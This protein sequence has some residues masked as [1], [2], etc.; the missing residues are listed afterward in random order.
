M[1]LTWLQLTPL[2]SSV[3]QNCSNSKKLQ[4]WKPRVFLENPGFWSRPY[5]F[6]GFGSHG[7]TYDWKWVRPLL[8]H[9]FFPIPK[10]VHFFSS[11]RMGSWTTQRTWWAT[12]RQP[13]SHRKPTQRT[14]CRTCD[15]GFEVVGRSTKKNQEKSGKIDGKAHKTKT[16]F[17][18]AVLRGLV[19]LRNSRTE[20]LAYLYGFQ[21]SGKQKNKHPFWVNNF[22]AKPWF[23]PPVLERRFTLS[24]TTLALQRCL[25]DVAAKHDQLDKALKGYSEVADK[26]TVRLVMVDGCY[27]DG[28][29]ILDMNSLW[30]WCE[31]FNQLE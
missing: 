29:V 5:I 8:P 25:K 13:T 28:G 6:F 10:R 30:Y 12:R 31:Y 19:Q 2:C 17:F 21:Q 15:H 26:A 20:H 11:L 1:G 16:V 22:G 18:K 7:Y 24:W 9:D 14:W 3:L 23:K 4:I 27:N